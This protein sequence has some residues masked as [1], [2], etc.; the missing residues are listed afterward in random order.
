MV[1]ILREPA[2]AQDRVTHGSDALHD[3]L[4]VIAPLSFGVRTLAP[5][6]S[7]FAARDPGPRVS[8]DLDDRVVDLPASGADLALRIGPPVDSTQGD[9]PC[10][11]G[12]P[13]QE[14][15]ERPYQGDGLRP[16]G[17]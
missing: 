16:I 11:Q 6:L 10:H 1:R 12:R 2:D 4:R 17:L 9:H 14:P 7:G 3:N 8:L 15:P 13:P 5:L